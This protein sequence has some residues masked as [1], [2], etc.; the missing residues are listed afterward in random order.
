MSHT[1]TKLLD[2]NILITGGTNYN[3]HSGNDESLSSAEIY[4]PT[5]DSWLNIAP[6]R[7]ARHL[8]SSI[9]LDNGQVLVVG[10]YSGNNK[11]D[12]CE[13]YDPI[14][15]SWSD[16]ASLQYASG[17]TK[18]VK[19]D[20]GKVML[21][22][23]A[24][25]G[26][27]QIYDSQEDTWARSSSMRYQ[28]G[29][30]IATKL[31]DGRVFVTGWAQYTTNNKASEIYSPDSDSFSYNP[32]STSNI[33]YSFSTATTLLDGR[34]ILIGNRNNNVAE[35]FDPETLSFSNISMEKV[36]DEQTANLLSDGRLAVFGG[37]GSGHEYTS[38]DYMRRT[39]EIFSYAPTILEQPNNTTINQ[40]RTAT[41]EVNAGGSSLTYQ[42]YKDGIV[43]A[44]SNENILEIENAQSSDQGTYTV[45]VSNAGGSTESQAVILDVIPDADSDGLA[46]AAETNTG[47]FVDFTNTGTSPNESDSD[48][49]TVSDYDEIFGTT[50]SNPNLTDTDSDG[51]DDGFELEAGFDPSDSESSP[52]AISGI[53]NAVYYHLYSALEATYRIEY[54][55]DLSQWSVLEVDIQGN[56]EKIDRY[57]K[58][59]GQP[60]RYF[61]AVRTDQ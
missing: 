52:D 39:V 46:D 57:Y 44:G 38:D 21:L 37:I 35:I 40:G 30:A 36:R 1:A 48:G 41:F 20:D 13:L 9:L 32:Y 6:M 50:P 11:L 31:L 25:G 51:F 10:G 23:G 17:L 28:R 43:L 18:A 7:V 58:I 47:I 15:Q 59:K 19:L 49:D 45:S 54:S 33:Y 26:I 53:E 24:G 22:G 3:N 5:T 27:C 14:T 34:V 61:R 2:G 29:K 42:W 8:H 55:E 4:D 12:S 60:K 16:A 56:G